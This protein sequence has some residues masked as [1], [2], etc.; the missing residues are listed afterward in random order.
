MQLRKGNC[1]AAEG[2]EQMS[3]VHRCISLRGV[4]K[5]SSTRF[6]VFLSNVAFLSLPKERAQVRR[7][8]RD[9][10]RRLAWFR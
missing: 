9:L 1:S 5:K 3:F 8:D 2:L 6:F 10:A 4:L 7:N